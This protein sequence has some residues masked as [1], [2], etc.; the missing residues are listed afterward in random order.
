MTGSHTTQ[1]GSGAAAVVT[2]GAVGTVR[3]LLSAAVY[4]AG[5]A[6]EA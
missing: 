3:S 4:V 6:G 5:A 1:A 2:P